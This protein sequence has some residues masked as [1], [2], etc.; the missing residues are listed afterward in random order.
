MAGA[1][2]GG[3]AVDPGGNGTRPA[4]VARPQRLAALPWLLPLLWR[5]LHRAPTPDLARWLSGEHGALWRLEGRE[6]WLA[7]AL[8]LEG[9]MGRSRDAAALDAR[10]NATRD[11]LAILPRSDLATV[12]AVLEVLD[13]HGWAR[14]DLVDCDRWECFL[15]LLDGLPAA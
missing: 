9:E 8:E 10:I 3:P 7:L 1:A 6:L 12:D 14:P 11:W 4:A 15:A 2:V 5:V 13:G